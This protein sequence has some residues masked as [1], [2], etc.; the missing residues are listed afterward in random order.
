MPP[1][2]SAR[3]SRGSLS[4]SLLFELLASRRRR[5]ILRYLAETDGPV[6]LDELAVHIA[7]H[8]DDQQD[9]TLIAVT[10]VHFHLPQLADADLVS[11]D[12]DTHI[13]EAGPAIPHAAR[14]LALVADWDDQ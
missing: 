12:R 11:F 7:D 1:D 10:L 6:F 3:E 9:W 5:R 4:P 2:R 13:V 14:C 8:E